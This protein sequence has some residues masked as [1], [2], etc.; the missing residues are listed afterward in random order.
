MHEGYTPIDG[1]VFTDQMI[2]SE[3]WLILRI[4]ERFDLV[5]KHIR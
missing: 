1:I 5:T 4:R 3:V 2:W